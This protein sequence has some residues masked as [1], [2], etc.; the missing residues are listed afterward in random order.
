MCYYWDGDPVIKL[1]DTLTHLNIFFGIRRLTISAHGKIP[2]IANLPESIEYLRFDEETY[3]SNLL[4]LIPFSV[5]KL[6]L[7]PRDYNDID[8]SRPGLKIKKLK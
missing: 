8:K 2:T 6:E 7:R 4:N 5:K 3:Q 1:P